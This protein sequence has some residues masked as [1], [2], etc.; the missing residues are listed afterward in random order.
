MEETEREATE[1]TIYVYEYPA[2][3]QSDPGEEGKVITIESKESPE[4]EVTTVTQYVEE[5]VEIDNENVV[6]ANVMAASEKGSIKLVLAEEDDN[7]GEHGYTM[8]YRPIRPV[9]RQKMRPWLLEHLDSGSIPGL[10]WQNRTQRIF[11]IS[12]KHAAHNCF[13]RTRDSDLFERWAYHTGRH[14]DGN[15][16]RWKANFRCA[17]NSLPDVIELRD[18]GVRKGDNAFKVYKFID[19]NDEKEREEKKRLQM[20][21]RS[22]KKTDNKKGSSTPNTPAGSKQL[23]EASPPAAFS[24]TTTE[25]GMLQTLLHAI[26]LKN[27]EAATDKDDD[28]KSKEKIQL[29]VKRSLDQENQPRSK[30]SRRETGKNQPS[31]E[32]ESSEEEEDY[33]TESQGSSTS[34]TPG[35]T[36]TT[37]T[38]GQSVINML[39]L[40]YILDMKQL[41]ALAGSKQKDIEGKGQSQDKMTITNVTLDSVLQD[42]LTRNTDNSNVK[43]TIPY[44]VFEALK[45]K[46]MAANKNPVT[47]EGT[48]SSVVLTQALDNNK[49]TT[50]TTTKPQQTVVSSLTSNKE[51]AYPNI[52]S[53]L[54]SRLNISGAQVVGQG[55]IRPTLVPEGGKKA[56]EKVTVQA[57]PQLQPVNVGSS[58]EESEQDSKINISPVNINADV[59]QS[60]MPTS[61]QTNKVSAE[62]DRVTEQVTVELGELTEDQLSAEVV[63]G[64]QDNQYCCLWCNVNFKTKIELLGHFISLHED[65]LIP[66]SDQSV[67]CQAMPTDTDGALDLSKKPKETYGNSA[68]TS[69]TNVVDLSFTTLEEG[70]SALDLSNSKKNLVVNEIN[71]PPSEN[72]PQYSLNSLIDALRNTIEQDRKDKRGPVGSYVMEVDQE[73]DQGEPVMK[74]V[75]LSSDSESE[76]DLP[77][78]EFTS[79][80]KISVKTF[81]VNGKTMYRCTKCNRVFSKSCTLSR[82]ALVHTQLFPYLCGICDSEFRDMRVLLKH[83]DLHGEDVDCPCQ[84]CEKINQEKTVSNKEKEGSGKF[85]FKC[86]IC[87]K[88]F[89]SAESCKAHVDSHT[90]GSVSVCCSI[91]KMKFSCHRA[92]NRH[93]MSSHSLQN[94]PVCLESSSDLAAHMVNHP[95]VFIYKCGLCSDGFNRR[96]DLHDHLKVHTSLGNTG[97]QNQ[98]RRRVKPLSKK[99]LDARL[100]KKTKSAEKKAAKKKSVAK[101]NSKEKTENI[102]VETFD[103]TGIVTKAVIYQKEESM[104]TETPGS[105]PK[106]K[107]DKEGTIGNIPH[108]MMIDSSVDF[109]NYQKQIKEKQKS[110]KPD[111]QKNSAAKEE[112]LPEED[113]PSQEYI[114]DKSEGN[115]VESPVKSEP[116]SPKTSSS[117]SLRRRS[118]RRCRWHDN[119]SVCERC[120][121]TFIK[122]I[123]F[124]RKQKKTSPTSSGDLSQ[125]IPPGGT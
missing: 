118:S 65:M 3:S 41:L 9:E 113:T 50:E 88:Q 61:S 49:D 56:F 4:D 13:N 86:D 66:E 116:S 110:K 73:M 74:F 32:T 83:L 35:A 12:W 124:E 18:L 46:N 51:A 101:S 94:C 119:D 84:K 97:P 21:T 63:G 122:T 72:R 8:N 67:N 20:V 52:R 7:P 87:S 112:S 26:E 99:T 79:D 117:M 40:P 16:K 14:H 70:E 81:Q 55:Q 2:N 31:E 111:S 96:P 22:S 114:S 80:V 39:K 92:L 108:F 57:I 36:L 58:G 89:R 19:L 23:K 28:K 37:P 27:Q 77:K 48:P 38:S 1:E 78:Q 62:L 47:L 76:S 85:K 104:E 121:G 106:P 102:K 115:H 75:D 105:T 123:A 107:T 11:R 82:H 30:R 60:E 68:E 54:V 53:R 95:G 33:E 109:D 120:D 103:D 98:M 24:I 25:G 17:L 100:L 42:R 43:I 5:V 6:V 93:R 10:S 64:E 15:H 59:S 69:Y 44:T 125:L 45:A 34:H 29:T 90:S 91:C 71:V